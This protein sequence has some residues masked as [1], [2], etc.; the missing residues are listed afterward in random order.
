MNQENSLYRYA[1]A[2]NGFDDVTFFSASPGIDT[3]TGG[4]PFIGGG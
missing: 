2:K 4:H 3:R 1:A